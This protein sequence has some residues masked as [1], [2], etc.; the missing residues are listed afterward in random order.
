MSI[1]NTDGPG[2]WISLE[3]IAQAE[4]HA[5]RMGGRES[6]LAD[7]EALAALGVIHCKVQARAELHQCSV[8]SGRLTLQQ[9]DSSSTSH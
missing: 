3:V 6:H 2:S 8:P 9:Q 1:P 7:G 4:E 5:Q